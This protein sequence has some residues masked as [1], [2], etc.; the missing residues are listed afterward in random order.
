[1]TRL[2][3]PTTS[4]HSVKA[5]TRKTRSRLAM[6]RAAARACVRR[7]SLASWHAS[8]HSRDAADSIRLAL[9]FVNLVKF[10]DT[11]R[12]RR[13]VTA[14]R[15]SAGPRARS[16]AREPIS[17]AAACCIDFWRHAMRHERNAAAHE[18][19]LHL[20]TNL[21]I[22]SLIAAASSVSSRHVSNAL[23]IARFAIRE[24]TRRNRRLRRVSSTACVLSAAKP[25]VCRLR[26]RRL[27]NAR[28]SARS[29]V[30]LPSICS[31]IR[32][33]YPSASSR[34]LT[35]SP[36]SSSTC[37]CAYARSRSS[38]FSAQ[39]RSSSDARCKSVTS[40]STA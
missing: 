34:R 18:A 9:R 20:D 11:P 28:V 8:N 35:H 36:T 14:Q 15:L 16:L 7:R 23:A 21:A 2:S 26:R 29:N 39:P 25:R 22:R 37:V 12:S 13:V 27:A 30:L 19:F 10:L 40:H 3:A 4:A 1:M 31:S 6:S 38:S 17:F 5:P 32:F 33:L 24:P